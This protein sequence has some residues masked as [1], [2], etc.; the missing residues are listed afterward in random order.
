MNTKEMRN[1]IKSRLS[2]GISPSV[3]TAWP[4][5]EFDP[6][7]LPRFE[8]NFVVS[9]GR[10][11]SLKGGQLDQ[12]EGSFSIV[13][14]VEKGTGEDAALDYA[15]SV[16]ALFLKGQSIE[17]TGGHIVV[18]QPPDIRIGFPDDTSYRIPVV[19]QYRASAE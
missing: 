19:V 12:E 11:D 4:N 14:C 13:V 6:A 16:K 10:D 17:F 15:D 9:N 5:V 7:V 8:L 1:S 2:S 3:S 18:T